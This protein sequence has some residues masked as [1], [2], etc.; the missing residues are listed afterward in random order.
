VRKPVDPRPGTGPEAGDLMGVGL[1]F[2]A[3]IL[4]F[5]FVGRW[6]DGRLGTEPWL[7]IAGVFVGLTAGFWSLYY[8]LVVE[9]RHK[10]NEERK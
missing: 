6:L 8:R 5:F 1:Q 10:Q 3:S 9:P 4:L 7:M 2:A